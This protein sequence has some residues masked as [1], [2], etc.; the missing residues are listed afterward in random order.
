VSILVLKHILRLTKI[1]RCLFGRLLN[2]KLK[3][4]KYK[5]CYTK[6]DHTY[7]VLLAE[8]KLGEILFKGSSK[9]TFKVLPPTIDKKTRRRQT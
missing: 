6:Q 7:A 5:L 4:K 1:I 9:G 8:A 2:I 3:K